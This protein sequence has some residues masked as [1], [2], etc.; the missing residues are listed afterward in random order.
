MEKHKRRGGHTNMTNP[1]REYNKE[2]ILVHEWLKE[3]YEHYMHSN[4]L[5][6]DDERRCYAHAVQTVGYIAYNTTI[7]PRED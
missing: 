4:K 6:S 2:L 7:S 1:N 3:L 5:K